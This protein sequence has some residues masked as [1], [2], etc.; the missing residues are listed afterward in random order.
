MAKVVKTGDNGFNKKYAKVLA[1]TNS[2]F[3]GEADAMSK[4][5]LEKV[6]LESEA[7]IEEQEKLMEADENLKAA[8]AV[9][10][11][12]A[13]AYKD[14]SRYQTSKIKYCLFNLERMGK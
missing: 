6:I 5:E 8:K 4:E 12:L 13:G 11:D 7:S 3:M 14:A 2:S 9:V 10:K 1:N